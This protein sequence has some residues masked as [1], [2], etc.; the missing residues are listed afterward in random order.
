MRDRHV[1]HRRPRHHVLSLLNVDAA[2]RRLLKRRNCRTTR[3]NQIADRR[4]VRDLKHRCV[5]RRR[6]DLG[7]RPYCWGVDRHRERRVSRASPRSGRGGMLK[8]NLPVH[9]TGNWHRRFPG[10]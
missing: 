8:Q 7:Q 3:A 5:L 10:V 9:S 2:T 1:A 4:A 6:R